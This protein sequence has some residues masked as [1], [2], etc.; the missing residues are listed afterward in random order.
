MANKM[1]KVAVEWKGVTYNLVFNLNV[2][3]E[4]QEEYGSISEWGDLTDNEKEPNAK[5]VIFGLMCM[6][7]E[8]I[9][10]DNVD[11]AGVAGYV[12]KTFLSKKQVGRLLTDVG[13]EE[14]TQRLN[15]TVINSVASDEKN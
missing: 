7:N 12:P 14:A 9:D 2:M 10:I 3:E 1:E 11:N 13:M 5:A 8:G 6:I 4:I 15:D